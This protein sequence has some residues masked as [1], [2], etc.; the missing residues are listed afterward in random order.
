VVCLQVHD[1]DGRLLQVVSLLEQ[2]GF[3]NITTEQPPHLLG[4]DLHNLYATRH[5][6]D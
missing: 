1:I 3:S 6:K 4:T 5:S 2:H